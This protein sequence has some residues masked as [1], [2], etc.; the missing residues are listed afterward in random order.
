[1][2]VVRTSATGGL[3]QNSS[4]LVV[5]NIICP[6]GSVGPRDSLFVDGLTLTT[7]APPNTGIIVDRAQGILRSAHARLPHPAP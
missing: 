2:R 7:Y 5:D 4:F 3:G 6:T 1:M